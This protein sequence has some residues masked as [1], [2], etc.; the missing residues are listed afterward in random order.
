ML[1]VVSN[2]FI[3][4]YG[5]VQI[6]VPQVNVICSTAVNLPTSYSVYICP[7]ATLFSAYNW[8]QIHVSTNSPTFTTITILLYAHNQIEQNKPL[9]SY[10]T[11]VGY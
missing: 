2:G 10:Y 1:S 5:H 6:V 9:K 3:I 7:L 8:G 11:T 4:C